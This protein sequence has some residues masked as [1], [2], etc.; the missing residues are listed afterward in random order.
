[1]EIFNIHIFEFVLIAGLALVVFGPERLPEVG[2]FVGKQVARVLAWQQQ[3]PE[4]R[5]LQDI[6]QEFEQEIVAL[7][8][9][10]VRTRQ[11]LDV[12]QEV[13][14]LDDQTKAL[15]QGKQPL[16]VRPAAGLQSAAVAPNKLVTPAEAS[17]TSEAAPLPEVAAETPAQLVDSTGT[18]LQSDLPALPDEL[19][20]INGVVVQ[21]EGE[22]W[23]PFE[24]RNG[25]HPE[26]LRTEN[27]ITTAQPYD[28]ADRQLLLRQLQVLMVDLQALTLELQERGML[29]PDWQ[30]PSQLVN[31]ERIP[32]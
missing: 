5:M 10:L 29:A 16:N 7:R 15:L 27:S 13:K 32:Q 18:P 2:R 24:Q 20:P 17:A 31:Q 6:R 11:Q 30:P 3:S 22:P 25:Q 26:E 4:A 21:E 28:Q 19:P 23:V 8:D 14:L 12:S 1:M 9:E